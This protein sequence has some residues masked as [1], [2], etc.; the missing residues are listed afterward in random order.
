MHAYTLQTHE[1]INTQTQSH[2]N[3]HK[4]ISLWLLCGRNLVSMTTES[5]Y[6]NSNASLH[7]TLYEITILV[8]S[9]PIDFFT[10]IHGRRCL[11]VWF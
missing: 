8:S 11:D 1:H 3:T 2:T 4:H 6:Q 7:F 9:V 5:E 10:M